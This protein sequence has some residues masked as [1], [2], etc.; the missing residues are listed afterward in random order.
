MTVKPSVSKA[1]RD[2]QKRGL[3]KAM[4][5][6]WEVYL[7]FI[8]VLT[9]FIIFCYIP[10]GGLVIAFKDFSPLRGIFDSHWV[11]MKHFIKLF[12]T[13]SFITAVKNTVIISALNLLIVFPI[14]ILFAILL[15]EVQCTRFKKLVQTVSYLP[16]FISWSV[17][18][19]LVYMLLA[20]NTGVINHLIE[21]MGGTPQNF[22]GMSRYFRT[23]LIGSSIW[24]EMG[25]SAI[26]YIAAISGVDEQL[27][28][29]AYIDGAGRLKRIW[30]ITLPG[31][32][33][34]IAVLLI[35]QVGNILS[36]NFGQIF[37]MANDTVMDVA[38]TIDYYVYRVGL[39]SSNN[40]SVAAAAG[41]IKSLVGLVLVVLT[42]KV[43]KKLT[44]GE[45][46]W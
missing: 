5:Q 28:E 26:V 2:V 38:E 29:A 7:L 23:I 24:G 15:N 10:M 16:H 44:D 42:N 35:L 30:H 41:M 9:W 3:R 45:G 39:K 31:I 8:P 32:S 25:W 14:P 46:I 18:A 21:A 19:S 43:S 4:S 11:G 36:T 6:Y 22:L 17:V 37:A 13:P 27:Y 40:F 34:T 1:E 12:S 33:G 20:P